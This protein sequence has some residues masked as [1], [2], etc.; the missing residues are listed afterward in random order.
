[1]I[2]NQELAMPTSCLNKA[3]DDE[4][5]FVLRAKDPLAADIVRIWAMMAHRSPHEIW[6]VKEARELANQMDLWR[7]ARSEIGVEAK[8]ESSI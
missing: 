2:K 7:A 4:P 1:M 8:R 6:K 3:Q 5:V